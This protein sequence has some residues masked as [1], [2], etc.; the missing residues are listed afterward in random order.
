MEC[1]RSPTAP[2]AADATHFV[3]PGERVGSPSVTSLSRSFLGSRSCGGAEEGAVRAMEQ[4]V[5]SLTSAVGN[6]L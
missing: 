4:A 6:P 2:F 3:A 1:S 5:L